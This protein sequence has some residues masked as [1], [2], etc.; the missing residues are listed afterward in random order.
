MRFTKDEWRQMY[1]LRDELERE[2]DR[3]LVR[4]LIRY[5][6]QL[7]KKLNTMKEALKDVGN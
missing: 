3:A 2:E 7:E 5:A 4:R 1:L 6:E